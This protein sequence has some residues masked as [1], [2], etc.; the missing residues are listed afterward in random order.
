[1]HSQVAVVFIKRETIDKI[2]ATFLISRTLKGIKIVTK[3]GFAHQNEQ[4]KAIS[5]YSLN[6]LSTQAPNFDILV[7]N[8]FLIDRFY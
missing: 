5:S 8:Y 3:A 6:V 4:F 7:F 2:S 1:M